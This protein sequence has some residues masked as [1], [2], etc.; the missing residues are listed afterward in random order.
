MQDKYASFAALAAG[1]EIA[2]R[3]YNTTV[4]ERPQSGVLIVAPHGGNIEIGTTELADLI[5]GTQYSLFAFNGLKTRGRNRELHI[6]SHNFDH[7]ECVALAAR[8][9]VVLAVHG[10]KGDSS[11]IYVGGLDG[12]LTTLLTKR[13]VAAGLPATATGHKYPGRNPLNICNRGARARG[14]QLEF[15]LDLRDDPSSRANMAPIV[16]SAVMEFVRFSGLP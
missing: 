6:T 8:H 5:A 3:D 9:P 14:A 2:G 11:H 7:P 1:G 10:C 16:R 15:T 13:L 4:R 12:E